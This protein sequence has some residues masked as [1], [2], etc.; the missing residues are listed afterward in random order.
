MGHLNNLICQL[1]A[2]GIEKEYDA[3]ELVGVYLPS[4]VGG[5]FYV[6][7]NNHRTQVRG[8]GLYAR[9]TSRV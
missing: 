6:C 9:L 2:I 4:S 5:I 1:V 3:E 7:Y 8:L